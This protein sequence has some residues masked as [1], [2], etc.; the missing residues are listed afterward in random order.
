MKTTIRADGILVVSPE[1]GLEAYALGRWSATN[2]T[3]WYSGNAK[4]LNIII[5][6]SEYPGAINPVFIG[7]G[8]HECAKP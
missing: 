1:N 8:A 2:L 7:L 5:D 6:C 3:D 4:Q